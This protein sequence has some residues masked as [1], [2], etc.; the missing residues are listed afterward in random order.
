MWWICPVSTSG[1][2]R[3]L[4]PPLLHAVHT[5]HRLV[6]FTL[7]GTRCG[8]FNPGGERITPTGLQILRFQ[9][10]TFQDITA[11]RKVRV[12]PCASEP[13]SRELGG[14]GCGVRREGLTRACA[15]DERDQRMY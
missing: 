13:P 5:A 11:L 2:S 3:E 12:A 7:C 1:S 4:R 8:S 10:S 6:S 14:I 9:P 15:R